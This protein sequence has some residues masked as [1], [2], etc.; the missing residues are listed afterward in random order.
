MMLFNIAFFSG[1]PKTLSTCPFFLILSIKL[2]RIVDD[3][4]DICK[5]AKVVISPTKLELS[6]AIKNL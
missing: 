1:E 2:N 3:Q 6:M 5:I 4:I